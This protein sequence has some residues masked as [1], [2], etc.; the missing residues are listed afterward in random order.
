LQRV[1]E[2]KLIPVFRPIPRQILDSGHVITSGRR[3]EVIVI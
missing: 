2:E 1:I 3:P